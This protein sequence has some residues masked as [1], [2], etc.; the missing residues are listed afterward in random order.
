ML[1]VN[2]QQAEELLDKYVKDDIVKMHCLE[3]EAIMRE[4][5]KH[6][7]ED[8]EEWGIIGLLHDIDWDLTKDNPKEHTVKAV[9]ILKQAGASD[10]LIETIVSHGYGSELCGI[11][12][13]KARTTKIQHA[14]AAAETLTGLIIASALVQPEKKLASVKLE[15]LKKKFKAK[16][17]AA[18]CDREIIMECEKI[19]LSLDEFLAIGLKALQSISDKLG[20]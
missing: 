11:N 17:F 3:S 20:L 18:K 5:A 1:N 4:L 2:R 13:D 9:E 6:F 8:E 16:A 12:Q 15:S 19:G 10:F 7:N 14:L